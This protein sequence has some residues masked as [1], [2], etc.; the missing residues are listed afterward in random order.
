MAGPVNRHNNLGDPDIPWKIYITF[1]VPSKET[2]PVRTI[3]S[4]QAEIESRIKSRINENSDIT[5]SYETSVVPQLEHLLRGKSYEGDVGLKLAWFGPKDDFV[6]KGEIT[7]NGKLD[8]LEVDEGGRM[9]EMLYVVHVVFGFGK[10]F[11]DE[12]DYQGRPT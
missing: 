1:L 7:V 12:C 6:S 2:E 9:F 10:Y 8:G 5:T 11:V 4:H 3:L